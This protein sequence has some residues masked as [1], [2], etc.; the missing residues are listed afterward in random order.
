[1]ENRE[2]FLILVERYLSF[3]NT[4]RPLLKP[5]KA[6]SSDNLNRLSLEHSLWMLETMKKDTFKPLTTYSAWIS[7]IQ[8]SL[9]THGLID[10]KHEIEITREITNRRLIKSSP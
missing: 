7:W 4:L 6:V 10:L 1:M 5:K 3:I 9:Y 2:E 8:A